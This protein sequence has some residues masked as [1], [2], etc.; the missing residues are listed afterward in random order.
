MNLIATPSY[1]PAQEALLTMQ[2]LHESDITDRAEKAVKA[3]N[4]FWRN[5][6]A[7]PGEIAAAL[8]TNAKAVFERH[9]ATVAELLT[10][11]PGCIAPEDYT[12]PQAYAFNNDGSMTL[13]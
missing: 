6:A 5:P 10:L 12:P 11:K 3:F 8:G 9:A 13:L 4:F 2:A 1:T 7:T